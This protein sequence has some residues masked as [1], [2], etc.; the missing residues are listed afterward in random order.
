V[1]LPTQVRV[2]GDLKINNQ[3]TMLGDYNTT[4]NVPL[5]LIPAII[6]GAIFSKAT[7]SLLK[8]N[9]SYKRL[10]E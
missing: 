10:P 1:G 4:L 3:I 7:E 8:A 9:P 5:D 6:R 2:I